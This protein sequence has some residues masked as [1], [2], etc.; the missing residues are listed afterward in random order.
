LAA[1]PPVTPRASGV[2]LV[3]P[4]LDEE[5]AIAAVVRAVPAGLV[6]E[7][8][9]VDNGSG[10]RTA[11]VARAAGA[12]VVSEPRRGYGAA[13]WAGVL[14][15]SPGIDVVAFLDGDGSQDP[16]ELPRLLDPLRAGRADLVLGARRFTR[17]A[18]H[19][20]HAILGTRTVALVL[21]WRLGVSL[22]D[23][24]PFRAIRR[25]ALLDLRLSD[26]GFG[27]P[28]EMVAK[29][30]RAGLRIVE[31]EVSQG[32]RLG[33]RSKVAGTVGGSLRAGWRFIR[34]ALREG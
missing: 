24:G 1:E 27:W 2:A 23:L 32:P 25:S 18:D 10:D 5:A 9:V 26:R 14:A 8:L 21:R 12:R 22:H 34:V 15:L 11:D 7:V 28:V 33:G 20:W 19:P 30:A 31:V 29:A 6:D 16:A 17:W 13:C 3:I 4:A